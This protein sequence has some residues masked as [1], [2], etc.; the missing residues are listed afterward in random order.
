MA[1]RIATVGRLRLVGSLVRAC[2]IH[3]YGDT[4]EQRAALEGCL[5]RVL[6]DGLELQPAPLLLIDDRS[7]T[8]WT[9][10]EA[11]RVLRD[12]GA[13]PVL[14]FVLAIEG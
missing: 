7:D 2:V 11:T 12:A 13:G 6:G 1:T 10:A 14:P 8:G 5:L 9:I 4:L 3:P